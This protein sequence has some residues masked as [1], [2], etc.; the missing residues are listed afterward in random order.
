VSCPE[1]RLPKKQ[2]YGAIT[3]LNFFKAFRS[4]EHLLFARRQ[5]LLSITQS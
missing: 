3:S 5:S 2:I 4:S 1:F